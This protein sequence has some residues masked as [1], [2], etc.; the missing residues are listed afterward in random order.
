MAASLCEGIE[1]C[2]YN[3]SF[4]KFDD[5][6]HIVSLY[7]VMSDLTIRPPP[8]PNPSKTFYHDLLLEQ[9]FS[10]FIFHH[11]RVKV[12]LYCRFVYLLERLHLQGVYLIANYDSL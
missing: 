4:M 2:C 7:T 12:H 8:D 11:T 5:I 6:D 10:E 3:F 1:F 9:A